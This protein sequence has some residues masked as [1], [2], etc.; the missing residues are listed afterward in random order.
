MLAIAAFS[1][2]YIETPLRRS[3]WFEKQYKALGTGVALL[4][5]VYGIF[6]LSYKNNNVG[7]SG[8]DLYQDEGR[9]EGTDLTRKNCHLNFEKRINDKICFLNNNHENTIFVFGD[10]HANAILPILDSDYIHDRYN[11]FTLTG[12]DAWF[13][14]RTIRNRK[15]F[16]K[17]NEKRLDILKQRVVE[18]DVIL[19]S[20]NLLKEL[21]PIHPQQK[22][23]KVETQKADDAI[24][25][26]MMSVNSLANKLDNKANIILFLLPHLYNKLSK[27]NLPLIKK[28]EITRRLMFN[29]TF[30]I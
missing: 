17:F 8:N 2:E 10:S 15:E 28:S 25:E 6:Y 29:E 22:N 7:N 4:I 19:I 21:D 14:T 18:G 26:Y 24:K 30:K 23:L 1:F 9:I 12:G 13:P 11:I 5:Y 20:N 3:K 16:D 27:T